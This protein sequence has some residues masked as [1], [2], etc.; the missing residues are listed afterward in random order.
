MEAGEPRFMERLIPDHIRFSQQRRE[1][2][3]RE[4]VRGR[5][6]ERAG[7]FGGFKGEIQQP[8]QRAR[9][10]CHEKLVTT[11]MD[12]GQDPDDFFFILD[13]CRQQLED[14]GQLVHDE[15]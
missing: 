1:K 2:I 14:M 5:N 3:R 13:E 15:R 9:Q 4:A 10:T 8:H 11:R 12:P 7:G 6:R